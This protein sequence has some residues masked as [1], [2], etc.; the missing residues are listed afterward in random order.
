MG[1]YGRLGLSGRCQSLVAE[2][3]RWDFRLDFG[4]DTWMMVVSDFGCRIVCAMGVLRR[5]FGGSGAVMFGGI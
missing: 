4:W 2:C 5:G 3:L 1:A